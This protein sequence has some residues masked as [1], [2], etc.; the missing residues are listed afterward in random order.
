MRQQFDAET[1]DAVVALTN[2][3]GE[4]R[5]DYYCRVRANDLARQVKHADI[6]DNLDPMRTAKLDSAKAN[7][8]RVKYGKA[9]VAVFSNDE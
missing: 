6:H 2:F 1:V 8:F 7:E 9:L 5:E 3:E 4:S